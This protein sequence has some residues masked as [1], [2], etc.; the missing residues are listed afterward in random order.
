[1]FIGVWAF[2]LFLL[3]SWHCGSIQRMLSLLHLR[4]IRLGIFFGF[5]YSNCVRLILSLC[6]FSLIG[7][8]RKNRTTLLFDILMFVCKIPIWNSYYICIYID[9]GKVR[10]LFEL[11]QIFPYGLAPSTSHGYGA[12]LTLASH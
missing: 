12:G 11:P 8:M 4:M 3:P 1:M 2:F 6:F 7:S 9:G 5:L 10:S